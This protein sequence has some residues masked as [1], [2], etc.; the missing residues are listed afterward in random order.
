M[1]KRRDMQKNLAKLV[2]LM[3]RINMYEIYKYYHNWLKVV[4]Y[5]KKFIIIVWYCFLS[6]LSNT[7]IILNNYKIKWL[8]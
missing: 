5:M 2:K 6:A 3:S 4:T 1:K 7:G 8:I